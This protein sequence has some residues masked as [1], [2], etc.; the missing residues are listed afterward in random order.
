M[1]FVLAARACRAGGD[2]VISSGSKFVGELRIGKET[3]RHG[4]EVGLA[5]TQYL[6]SEHRSEPPDGDDGDRDRLLEYLR[7]LRIGTR[8]VMAHIEFLREGT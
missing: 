7:H 2:I 1:L 5:F 3:S 6:F 8:A 4:D